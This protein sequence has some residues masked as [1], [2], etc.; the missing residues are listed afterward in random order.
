MKVNVDMFVFAKGSI[1]FRFYLFHNYELK[2]L[3]VF[4]NYYHFMLRYV[5]S[6]LVKPQKYLIT[7]GSEIVIKTF[8]ERLRFS[9][10]L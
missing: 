7:A 3:K 2:L 1:D 6:R 9:F 5:Y 4:N 10:L 8:K